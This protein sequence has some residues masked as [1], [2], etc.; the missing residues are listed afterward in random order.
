MSFDCASSSKSIGLCAASRITRTKFIMYSV[1]TKMNGSVFAFKFLEAILR[2]S[3]QCGKH[4]WF[5][6]SPPSSSDS[7]SSS[8]SC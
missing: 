8:M 5:V 3:M 1:S 7:F 4:C 2:Y 6:A